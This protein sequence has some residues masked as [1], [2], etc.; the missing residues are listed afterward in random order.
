[1]AAEVCQ[2]ISSLGVWG[3]AIPW[4]IWVVGIG[5]PRHL[6]PGACREEGALGGRG[7]A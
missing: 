7:M 6:R 5:I 1:M 2:G 3:G 4:H